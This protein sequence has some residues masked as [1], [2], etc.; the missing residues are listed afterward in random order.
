MTIAERLVELRHEKGL[1]QQQLA[2]E[3]GL[4]SSSIA[5]WELRQSEPTASAIIKLAEFF[6][7]TT[8]YILGVK[9]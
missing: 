4:S 3:T 1:T 6:E 5:R 9:D 7:E 8:D 2:D